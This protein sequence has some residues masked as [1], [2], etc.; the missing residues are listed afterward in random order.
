MNKL[1]MILIAFFWLGLA[2]CGDNTPEIIIENPATY[3][4]TRNGEST[5][6]F[7]GQTTRIEMATELI[8]SMIDFESSLESLNEMYS[9]Q[10]NSGGDADPFMKSELNESTKSIQSKVAASK[11]FFSA[12][13]AEGS[14]I[15]DQFSLWIELQVNEVIANQN[16]LAESGK[17]GQLADG[18]SVRYINGRGLE[19]NQAINKGLIGALMVDQ[20]LNNYLSP[21][22]L[23]EADNIE[24]NDAGTPEEGKSYTTMEHKWDEAYGYLFGL[25]T[26]AAEPLKTI[27]EDSFLNK[28]LARVEDDSDFAGI[29]S[30]VYEAFKLGRAAI[31][32]GD[33]ETR[34][35]QADIIKEEISKVIGIR[36]VYYMQ[37]G[38]IAL[39]N[40][41][42]GGAFHNL[43]EGYGFIYSL[44]FTRKLG[45]F[46][47]Y[48]SKSE[49]DGFISTLEAGA[50]FYTITSETLDQI[51]NDIAAKFD[52]TVSQAGS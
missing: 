10:T 1:I 26:N 45:S 4:F 47:P 51:S 28:Y 43:S 50:G 2:S 3:A 41:N 31:V 30:T 46:D 24:T 23:D 6:S 39:E 49:V 20:M 22:V 29:A 16:E 19:Y 8:A 27:G 13:T 36:A 35:K 15:K 34:D 42:Q 25:S 52:F 40:N 14:I 33:Y 7:S 48:F 32:V 5:V 38:K 21:S 18:S 17:P 37:Q 12:N 9:N 44:R 11:D